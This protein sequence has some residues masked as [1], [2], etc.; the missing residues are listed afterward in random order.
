MTEAERNNEEKK[1]KERGRDGGV[2]VEIE[3]DVKRKTIFYPL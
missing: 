1:Q 2:E 3:H